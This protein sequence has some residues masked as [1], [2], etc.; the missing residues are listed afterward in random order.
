MFLVLLKFSTNR[1]N[2]GQFLDGHNSWLREGF[3]KGLFILAGTLQPKLRGAIL[4]HNT[5]TDQ[6]K[7]FTNEDP[8]VT[9][10]VV[11]AEIVEITP[12]KSIPELNFLLPQ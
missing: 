12:S 6:I 3:E 10:N 8:F 1:A 5:T 4:A 2:A 11:T 9:E 7:A